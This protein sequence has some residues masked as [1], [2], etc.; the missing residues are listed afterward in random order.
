VDGSIKNK[1]ILKVG[2][3]FD[4]LY[5]LAQYERI[6][7]TSA[8]KMRIMISQPALRS[9]LA[10]KYLFYFYNDDLELGSIGQRALSTPL[11]LMVIL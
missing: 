9:C 5:E 2:S 10:A 7:K 3:Y 4:S 11:N 6:L 8:F 1:D